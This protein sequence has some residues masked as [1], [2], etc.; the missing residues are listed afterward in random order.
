MTTKVRIT[1]LSL[2]GLGIVV[3]LV[4]LYRVETLRDWSI[5]LFGGDIARAKLATQR[6]ERA[7]E[8]LRQ[9]LDKI[10]QELAGFHL[11]TEI[12]SLDEFEMKI[13]PLKESS[14]FLVGRRRMLDRMFRR[15]IAALRVQPARLFAAS[16]SYEALAAY[17]QDEF[18]R[19]AYM[20]QASACHVFAGEISPRVDHLENTRRKLLADLTYLRASTV[21]MERLQDFVALSPAVSNHEQST[22][23]VI[24]D[25]GSLP[26]ETIVRSAKE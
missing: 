14:K 6:S 21:L 16:K 25:S 5:D 24:G 26:I 13:E 17:E 3:C 12:E 23:E 18:L 4:A 1:T 9:L 22:K 7:N 8:E 20:E 2:Y 11:P 19:S 10:H 15:K